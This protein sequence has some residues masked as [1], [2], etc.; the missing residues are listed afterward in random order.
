MNNQNRTV[1]IEL[2][3][4]LLFAI[5]PLLCCMVWATDAADDWPQFRGPGGQGHA[6]AADPPIRWSETENVAWKVAVAGR[7]WSSPVVLAGDVWVTTGVE[8]S[9]TPEEHKERL[10]G[11]KYE[12]QLE[13][14]TS[15]SLRAVCIDR[16]S[17]RVR[18]DVELFHVERPDPIHRLNT[19]ASPTPAIEPG[20]IWCD[21]GTNGTACLDTTD[22][23]ILWK[24]RLETD[25]QVG[26]GSS[27]VVYK[28]LLILTRDGCDRQY[29]TALDKR[30]GET[31]WRTDRPNFETDGEFKKAF[32]TPLFVEHSGRP[33]MIVPGARWVIS[34]E[35][36]TGKP[37]WRVD[38]VKGYSNIAQPVFGHGM[39]YVCT[40]GPGR[41]L[42]A[43]RVDG[44]GDVTD[45]HVAWI[46]RKQVPQRASPVLIGT[47]LYLVTD[48]GVISCLDALTG[49]SRW[50]ARLEG[51]YSAS[52][53]YAGGR[54]YLFNEDAKTTIVAPDDELA[55]WGEN[56][57]SGRL[58]AT[59]AVAGDA[60]FLRTESHLY[61]I[62]QRGFALD[63]A[64][65][66]RSSF[67]LLE[68]E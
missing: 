42:W 59:P 23:Q 11:H 48:T 32:S 37:L 63:D 50:Q 49:Q 45:T 43:I 2:P 58:T 26:P 24:R 62:E 35:P 8:Q 53:I 55:V 60:I 38:Y 29:L 40:N 3:M 14:A 47:D 51:N 27:P 5:L 19:Y 33:Q 34:Y 61:R 65:E 17:G 18:H 44:L 67:S 30:T 16:V 57:L 1:S 52:P 54:I 66:K 15:V 25:H 22:G 10:G 41:Q 56:S 21:F 7:G 28:S 4:R 39:V 12:D 20:R 36:S 64:V 68:A 31:V 6:D 9:A 13:V 46:V